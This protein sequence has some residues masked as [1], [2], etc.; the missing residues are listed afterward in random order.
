MNS[1]T[2]LFRE[3]PRPSD[4]NSKIYDRFL[5][6]NDSVVGHL[7]FQR[8]I[9]GCP[10]GESVLIPFDTIFNL[11][12]MLGEVLGSIRAKNKKAALKRG[13]SKVLT[14]VH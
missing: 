6:V 2:L 7:R 4:A 12:P 8:F 5:E 13:G 3:R 10:F 14:R 9:N 1:L 11:F